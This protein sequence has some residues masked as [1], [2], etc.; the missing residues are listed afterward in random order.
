MEVLINEASNI[1]IASPI[2][3]IAWIVKY[4]IK[5]NWIFYCFSSLSSLSLSDVSL[6]TLVSRTA[7]KFVMDRNHFWSQQSF[8]SD[9]YR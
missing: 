4:R 8:D 9:D 7:W 2:L 3:R 5:L 6:N 1:E